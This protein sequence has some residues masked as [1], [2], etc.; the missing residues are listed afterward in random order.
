MF[1]GKKIRI[2]IGNDPSNITFCHDAYFCAFSPSGSVYFS[3]KEIKALF[4]CM[5]SFLTFLLETR[6]DLFF[7]DDFL[8]FD[9]FSP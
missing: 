7:Q 4:S 9:Y 2:F 3:L 6:N 5:F 8:F 1:F